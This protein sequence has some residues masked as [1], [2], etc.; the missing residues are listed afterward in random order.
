MEYWP[1]K[2]DALSPAI[3]PIRTGEIPLVALDLTTAEDPFLIRWTGGR[4]GLPERH[5][6]MMC[7]LFVEALRDYRHGIWRHANDP[8]GKWRAVATRS[9]LYG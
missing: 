6:A 3:Y 9:I 1:V 7:R 5:A 4:G 2:A 8:D